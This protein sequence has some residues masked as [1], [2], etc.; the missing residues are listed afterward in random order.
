MGM[1]PSVTFSDRPLQRTRDPLLTRT[2]IHPALRKAPPR[3][4]LPECPVV[5]VGGGAGDVGRPRI[6]EHR[7][8]TDSW[9]QATGVRECWRTA[10][11]QRLEEARVFHEV[12]P[13]WR[14][15]V[16]WRVSQDA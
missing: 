16:M 11:V 10:W 5:L 14:R 6:A 3:P 4:R 1:F 13:R 12:A 8:G 15:P 2:A 7:F 9:L